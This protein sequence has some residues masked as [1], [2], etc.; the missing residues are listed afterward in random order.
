[1]EPVFCSALSGGPVATIFPPSTAADSA[2]D[3][4]DA[5][6]NHDASSRN[7]GERNH[8]AQNCGAERKDEIDRRIETMLE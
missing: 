4:D 5:D 8:V 2:H 3:P 1:M 7:E 6:E